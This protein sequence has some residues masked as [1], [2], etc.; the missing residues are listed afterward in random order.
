M[1]ATR[2]SEPGRPG[3]RSQRYHLLCWVTWVQRFLTP[4]ETSGSASLK[5]M[6]HNYFLGSLGRRNKHL[7]RGDLKIDAPYM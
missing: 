7:L 3:F 4:F 6:T 1:V 5:W 2:H